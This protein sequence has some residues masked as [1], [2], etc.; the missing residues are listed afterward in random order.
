MVCEVRRINIEPALRLG[1]ELGGHIVTGHVDAIGKVAEMHA[2][3]G[4]T[5]LAI[6]APAAI[7]HFIA[8][9]GS[10]TLDGVSLKVNTVKDQIGRA[11][12]WEE[13]CQ[14]GMIWA[15]AGSLNN[16]KKR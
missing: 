15:V 4:S 2:E 14:V 3:G 11:S 6:H 10:I 9:T 1:D 7:A 16:K 13:V 12:W 5:H 8:A